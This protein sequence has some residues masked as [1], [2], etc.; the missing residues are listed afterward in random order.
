MRNIFV[1]A[2]DEWN[3]R[4]SHGFVFLDDGSEGCLPVVT[5]MLNPECGL[6]Y[7]DIDLQH[8]L[9]QHHW[10]VSGYKMGLNDPITEEYRPIFSDADK[11]KTM[12]R[13]VVK[14]NL[15]R[16]MAI[17]LLDAFSE[18]FKLMDS[19]DFSEIHNFKISKLRHKDQKII[20]NHC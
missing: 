13:I 10:Y 14:N 12:F 2:W 7:D 4:E 15:T 11:D 8:I 17:N 20:S 6:S 3:S 18:S 16:D 19:I 5:A 1:R 9:S